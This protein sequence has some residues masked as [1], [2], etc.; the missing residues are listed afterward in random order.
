[1]ILPD[2]IKLRISYFLHAFHFSELSSTF[3]KW[4]AV[5]SFYDFPWLFLMNHFE[6]FFISLDCRI[7]FRNLTNLDKFP[8]LYFKSSI[9]F[10]RFWHSFCLFI[11]TIICSLSSPLEVTLWDFVMGRA[12]VSPEPEIHLI[13]T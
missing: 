13:N 9:S 5:L 10:L 11:P 7:S 6:W 1:M 12:S 4:G 3:M 2:C 8:K